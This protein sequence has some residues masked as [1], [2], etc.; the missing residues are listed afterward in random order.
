MAALDVEYDAISANL[1]NALGLLPI[2]TR[3]IAL[4]DRP[5]DGGSTKSSFRSSTSMRK[6]TSQAISKN[7]S[8]CFLVRGT[9]PTP[10]GPNCTAVP[11]RYLVLRLEGF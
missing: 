4:Q 11:D 7:Q 6:A 5:S 9:T 10:Q 1:D 8:S 2:G 3:R